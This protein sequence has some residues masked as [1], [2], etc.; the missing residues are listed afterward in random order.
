M[1]ESLTQQCLTMLNRD[2]FKKE[3]RLI[4][5]PLI[6]L[7]VYELNPYIYIIVFLIALLFLMI[8]GILILLIYILRHKNYQ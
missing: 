8:L 6:N 5:S 2:D 7:I 4:L 3:L 1:K